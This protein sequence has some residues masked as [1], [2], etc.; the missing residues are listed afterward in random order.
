MLKVGDIETV[1]Q[2]ARR[3]VGRVLGR[4]A[5]VLMAASAAAVVVL[6]MPAPPEGP[7]GEWGR[8][9]E[10]VSCEKGMVPIND[11]FCIDQFEARTVE[12]DKPRTKKHKPQIVKGHSPFKRV[13]GL[14]VMAVS[15][16]GKMP[17][18]HIS[19]EEAA[20]ACFN[21]GKRLCSDEEWIEACQGKKPTL[22]PYGDAHEDGKCNDKGV[23][24]FNL[25]F[26]PGNNTPPEQSAYTVENMN[27]PRLNQVE[28]SLARTGSF[29][30]CKN[31]FKVYDMVGNLHEWTS[32]KQG[33]FRGGYY[34]D[35]SINGEGC[36]Y[37]TTAHDVKY[38]DYSTGF[39]CCSGGPEQAK[40]DKLRK[41]QELA[42]KEKKAAEKEKKLAL[43]K[44][45]KAAEKEKKAA[46]KKKLEKQKLAESEKKKKDKDKKKAP[47][48]KGSSTDTASL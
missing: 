11:K 47:K 45:E 39:R 19:Q 34:L 24:G 36:E 17:Q 31:G 7:D 44:K 13:T 20:E 32:N 40:A 33:T 1:I 16:R 14:H 46:E 26:G 37:R 35:T 12:I 9:A 43:E 2:A 30:K 29:G 6:L 21:A 22:Y 5:P 15:E 4:R 23:S 41:E 18:G 48:K 38:R 8:R 25:L 27:D 42:E 28:G 10:A 3:S